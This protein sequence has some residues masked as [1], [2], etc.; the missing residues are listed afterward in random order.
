MKSLF[1]FIIL[2]LSVYPVHAWESCYQFN[3]IPDNYTVGLGNYNFRIVDYNA[4][5]WVM[6][7]IGGTGITTAEYNITSPNG[8][9]SYPVLEIS[10]EGQDLIKLW[11]MTVFNAYG[12]DFNVCENPFQSPVTPTPTYPEIPT[13]TTT[14]TAT[15]TATANVTSD[16]PGYNQGDQSCLPGG[17]CSTY[18]D[19]YSEGDYQ[20]LGDNSLPSDSTGFKEVLEDNGYKANARGAVAFLQD[21]M[22]L[23]LFVGIVVF[24]GKLIGGF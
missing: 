11:T 15:A 4:S 20:N 12:V 6:Y 18:P 8:G 5:D 2:V 17:N 16:I 3:D 1:I 21:I 13:P 24:G 19:R 10:S 7:R 14:A 9:V 23:Y 22:I